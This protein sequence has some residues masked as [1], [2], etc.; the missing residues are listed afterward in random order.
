M[1]GKWNVL[2]VILQNSDNDKEILLFS[3]G[4]S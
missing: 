4:K 3:I 1:Y 2:K